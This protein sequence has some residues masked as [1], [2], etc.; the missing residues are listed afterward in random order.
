MATATPTYPQY[1]NLAL[2]EGL[3]DQLMATVKYHL[4]I[5]FTSQRLTGDNYSKVYLGSIEAVMANTTQ[6]LLGIMLIEEKKE[7]LKLQNAIL[8]LQRDELQFKID[9]IYP[10]ELQKLEQELL[11]ITAQVEKIGKEIEFLTAKI[12]TETA[13]V[14]GSGVT[15]D[16]LIGRQVALL[17]AQKLGFAGDIE[18]KVA[19]MHNDYASIFQTVQEVTTASTTNEHT[20]TAMQM[21]LETAQSMKDIAYVD[22]PLTTDPF[23]QPVIPPA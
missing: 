17:R 8:E 3:F 14:D 4:D 19:K 16:S 22:P 18:A 5:E 7:N 20:T 11:L 13:N 15:E 23:P 10:L 21:A 12:L 1:T 9:F 2:N 6:Y